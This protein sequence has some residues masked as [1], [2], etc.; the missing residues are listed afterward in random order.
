M[1]SISYDPDGSNIV[2]VNSA[3]AYMWEPQPDITTYELASSIR[4]LITGRPDG[5][6]DESEG[7]RRH[8]R[9]VEPSA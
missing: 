1:V 7:V 2:K 4:Y 5:L 3:S 6:D 8:W 9:K